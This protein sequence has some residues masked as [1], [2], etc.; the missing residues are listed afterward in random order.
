MFI[1]EFRV[2]AKTKTLS[3]NDT[4]FVFTSVVIFMD[5]IFKLAKRRFVAEKPRKDI[6]NLL[7]CK[8]QLYWWNLG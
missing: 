8:Y 7:P 2:L 4:N 5:N 3:E 6:N 1:L